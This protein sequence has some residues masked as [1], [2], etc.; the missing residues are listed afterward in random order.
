MLMVCNSPGMGLNLSPRGSIRISRWLPLRVAVGVGQS[1]NPG[2]RRA[3]ADLEAREH[4]NCN[5]ETHAL[6]VPADHFEAEGQMARDVLD[7]DAPRAQDA[8]DLRDRG[9]QVARVRAPASMPGG[10]ERLAR[11]TGSEDIHA[12]ARVRVEPAPGEIRIVV[13]DAGP[14]IPDADL[15]RVFEPFVRLEGSRDRNT[16]GTGLGLAIARDL[17]RG[18]GGDIRLANRPEG[19]LRATIHLPQ[20]GAV[21][22]PK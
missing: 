16:G 2:P 22:L 14:G 10:R 17:V 6:K 21:L 13:D 15:E 7:E 1:E 9:P 5:P 18:H 11:V 4:S 12:A 19:G 3:R 8:D 20:A